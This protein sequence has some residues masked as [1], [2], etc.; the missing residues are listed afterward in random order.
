MFCVSLQQFLCVLMTFRSERVQGRLLG[1]YLLYVS[2]PVVESNTLRYL[3]AAIWFPPRGSDPY[4][5]TAVHTRRNKTDHRTHK[6]V[7]KTYKAIKKDNKQQRQREKSSA[8]LVSVTSLTFWRRN[9]FF[10]ILAHP[11]YKM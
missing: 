1:N 10:L 8:Q 6:L 11:V 5:R 4:A 7:S 9:C 2:R 3:F